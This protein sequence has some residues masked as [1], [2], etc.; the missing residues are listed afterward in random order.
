MI[1][2]LLAHPLTRG[3][4]I[5]ARDTTLIRRR[6]IREKPFLRKLY[7]EWYSRLLHSIP[8]M[9]GAILELGSGA[10]FLKDMDGE[11][12][13]SE[14]FECDGVDM[15]VD[16]CGHLP[17]GDGELRAIVMTDVFHHLPDVGAFFGESARTVA[18]GGVVSMIEPWVTPW[19]RLVFT[20]FHHEP[21]DPEAGDWRFQST[22]P[23]SGANGALPWIVF[24]RD[25]SEFERKF[26]EWRIDAIHPM[27]PVAYLLS[28]GV[29]MRPL[30]PGWGYSIVRA[31]ERGLAGFGGRIAMFAHI[32]L[33]RV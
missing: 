20:K 3:L 14:V 4:D 27:M 10:G 24:M 5:D 11:V 22:G 12:V 28:G 9:R 13:T 30:F 33:R 1:R 26:P 31:V 19:S 6:V 32:T 2:D 23:L 16:A 17:F 29:S 15:R 18:R 7:T 21:F 25:R 8:D